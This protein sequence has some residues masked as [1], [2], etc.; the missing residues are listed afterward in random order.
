MSPYSIKMTKY[1][2]KYKGNFLNVDMAFIAFI[3]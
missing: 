1:V 2:Y 3:L